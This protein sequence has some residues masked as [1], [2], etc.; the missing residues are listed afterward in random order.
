MCQEEIKE[1]TK[2][3]SNYQKEGLGVI[4]LATDTLSGGRQ[5]AENYI[6][7]VKPPFPVGHASQQMIETI[8]IVNNALLGKHRPLPV[9]LLLLLDS[10]GELVAIYKGGATSETIL[11]DLKLASL[12]NTK[13]RD[14]ILP[15]KGKWYEREATTFSYVNVSSLLLDAGYLNSSYDYFEQQ[16]PLIAAHSRRDFDLSFGDY[17]VKNKRT[18]EAIT[19]FERIRGIYPKSAKPHFYLGLLQQEKGNSQAAIQYY[20][21]ALAIDSNLVAA[22]INTAFIL[23]SLK[24]YPEAQTI[25]EKAI[26]MNPDF[27][28][29][30]LQYAI[31]LERQGNRITAAE[32]YLKAH[33]LAPTEAL[34]ELSLAAYF[35]RGRQFKKAIKHYNN[36]IKKWPNVTSYQHQAAVTYEKMGEPRAAR[37]LYQAILKQHPEDMNSMSNLARIYATSTQA[38]LRDGAKAVKLAEDLVKKTKG[39]HPLSLDLLAASYAETSD[40]KQALATQQK[41]IDLAR[42]MKNK[43]LENFLLSKITQYKDKKPVRINMA[44]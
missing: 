24:Q 7:E 8:Q 11:A 2:H 42:L 32:H 37:T 3:Y 33:Q 29:A 25:L 20:K 10:K 39:Q 5:A 31:V 13:L 1:I 26:K 28:Q 16:K 21:N 14:A 43:R 22:H 9:P 34:F 6:N 23:S 27:P 36:L 30:Q 4:A 12:E 15:F 41:A 19:H 35:D 38:S 40:F 17:L 44:R 18:N